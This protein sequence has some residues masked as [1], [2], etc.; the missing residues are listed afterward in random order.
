[1]IHATTLL[2]HL[3]RY[4]QVRPVSA[5][6]VYR[7]GRSVRLFGEWLTRAALLTDLTDDTVNEWLLAIERT[8][9][10]KSV[11]EYRGDLLALWRWIASRGLCDPPVEIRRVKLPEPCPWSWVEEEANALAEQCKSLHGR[12]PNGV[13]RALYCEALVRFGYDTGLRRSDI[14]TVRRRQI[15]P[16]GTIV[17]AQHK[18]GHAHWPRLR[19]HTID[20]LKLLP[21]DPPLACPYKTT[22]RWYSFWKKYVTTPAGVR[23]GAIQQIRR[24]GATHLAKDHPEAVQRYLGHRTPEMQKYYIDW[25]VAKPQSH[26]PPD[27]FGEGA[28][29]PAD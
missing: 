2:D 14:W 19:P 11:K 25:S 17:L 6:T 20:L 8:H 22:S 18:T 23:H 5:S 12:F 13:S 10:R 4:V 9:S 28:P 29:R 7:M 15:R 24:T 16:D 1:M 21:G 26:L 3:A 27:I